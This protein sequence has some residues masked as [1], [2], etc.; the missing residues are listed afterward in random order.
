MIVTFT[1]S[2]GI[3]HS[4]A[5]RPLDSRALTRSEATAAARSDRAPIKRDKLTVI[6]F[7]LSEVRANQ[8][9]HFKMNKL[10]QQSSKLGLSSSS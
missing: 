2:V 10:G 6:A 3:P 4:A 8:L 7:S 9:R 1:A 5:P